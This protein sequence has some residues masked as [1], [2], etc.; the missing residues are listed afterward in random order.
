M[1]TP[2]ASAEATSVEFA[3]RFTSGAGLVACKALSWRMSFVV[4]VNE[5]WLTVRAHAVS[6]WCSLVVEQLMLMINK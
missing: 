4:A 2:G 3:G 5:S 6:P 1:T